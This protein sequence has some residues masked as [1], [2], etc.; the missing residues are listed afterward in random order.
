M[1]LDAVYSAVFYRLVV[2]SALLCFFSMCFQAHKGLSLK[3]NSQ[4]K[5]I[6]LIH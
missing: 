5:Q 4:F 3:V 2:V 1:G 6:C